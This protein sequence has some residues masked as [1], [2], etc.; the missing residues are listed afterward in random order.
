M[1][2]QQFSSFLILSLFEGKQKWIGIMIMM[3]I[4]YITE[5]LRSI[6]NKILNWYYPSTVSVKFV[7]KTD[8]N[9]VI[10]ENFTYK[11]ICW[12]TISKHYIEQKSL[13]CEYDSVKNNEN[14]GGVAKKI[15][16]YIPNNSYTV[17]YDNMKIVMSF[18][19][20]AE[21]KHIILRATSMKI[22]T[23]FSSYVG[24]IYADHV[25]NNLDPNKIYVMERKVGRYSNSPFEFEGKEM[26]VNKTYSNVYLSST[27]LNSIKNDIKTFISGKEFYEKSGIPYKRGYLL[28]GPPGTGKTSIAYAIA[29]ENKMNMY[30]LQLNDP[31]LKRNNTTIKQVAKLVQPKSVVLIEEVDTQVYNDRVISKAKSKKENEN[32]DEYYKRKTDTA[33]KIPMSELMEILDGYDTFHGCIVILTTNHKEYLDPA[34]IRPGR[35]DMHYYFGPMGSEDIKKTI[36]R[37]S[38]YNI[39]VPSTLRVTSSTLINQIL[40]S[41]R[42]DRAEIQK[43]INNHTT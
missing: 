9:G 13:I 11:A 15:P 28:Y 16:V 32:E 36:K 20:S 27:L 42:G 34:L 38:G 43:A 7:Q 18:G 40:I 35:V 5:I 3:F 22:L 8:K 1:K 23:D 17:I 14:I 33:N 31:I 26:T 4:P 37:F 24:K 19:G 39:Q 30:R 41:N 29:R 12:Y 2:T 6:K 10:I 25:F 21:V